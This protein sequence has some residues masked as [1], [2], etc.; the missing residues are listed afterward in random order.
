MWNT[1][2]WFTNKND[3]TTFDKRDC[4]WVRTKGKSKKEIIESAK[5]KAL[6]MCGMVIT[7]VEIN[8]SSFK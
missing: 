5:R 8:G 1:Q 3:E 6:L 4:F 2:V 7:D